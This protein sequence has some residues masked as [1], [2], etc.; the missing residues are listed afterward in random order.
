MEDEVSTIS[1]LKDF[2]KKFVDFFTDAGHWWTILIF[3][4]VL[5]VG[6]VLVKL[7]LRLINKLF[8]RTKMEKVTQKFI[9][10]VLKV[11]LY[12][13]LVLIL[14]SIIGI[15][16]S[17]II[18]ALSAVIL[19]IGLALEDCVVNIA[20]GIIIISTKM[21]RKGD[22]IEVGGL[23]G[24]VDEINFVFTAI[25]TVDNKRVT[26]PNS[27]IIGSSVQNYGANETRRV[28]FTFS[29]AYE[30]D[31]ETVKKIVTDVMTSDGR[32]LLEPKAP[33]CRLKT[34]GASSIDFFANCWCDKDDYWDVYYYVMENVY[35]EF[36]RNNISVPFTQ[37]EVRERKDEVIM[38]VIEQP[39]PERVEKVREEKK[40]KLDLENGDWGEY[41][42][43]RKEEREAKKAQKAAEN[44]EGGKMFEADPEAEKLYT[45]AL[46]Y[47]IR[48][49][50]ASANMIQKQFSVSATKAGMILDWMEKYG[51]V[52]APEKN[53]P[54]QVYVSP[55]EFNRL[56]SHPAGPFVQQKEDTPPDEKKTKTTDG[57][58]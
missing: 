10:T 7:I 13:I 32:V 57:K 46:K 19:A 27:T 30:S 35:N 40:A 44:P 16:I 45:D 43:D 8:S 50:K 15:V 51:Y 37:L 23:S 5:F 52:S 33:F 2:G 31:V 28:D 12:L 48:T 58:E 41:I 22:F 55:Y 47:C 1:S 49:G 26:I 29:V 17:G 36:K 9:M 24:N 11:V 53:K 20:D 21:F 18:T 25:M 14:L 38:P 6:I 56:Y 42:N 4:V 3:F 54:R 39:L 34:L